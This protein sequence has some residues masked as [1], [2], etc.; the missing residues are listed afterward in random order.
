[1]LSRQ[2]QLREGEYEFKEG[3]DEVK[4]IK[5]NRSS[6]IQGGQPQLTIKD[7]QALDNLA[8]AVAAGEQNKAR[9]IR[10][11]LRRSISVGF[12]GTSEPLTF[13]YL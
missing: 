4:P 10:S 6:Y 1:M 11:E 3:D 5:R 7:L 2:Y 8:T 12:P 9:K 13:I